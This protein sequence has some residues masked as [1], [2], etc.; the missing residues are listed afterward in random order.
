VLVAFILVANATCG[1]TT[2]LVPPTA[3][4][5]WHPAQLSRFIIGPSP[6][7]T[8]STSLKSSLPALNITSSGAVNPVRA[9]PA[10]AAPPRPPGSLAAEGPGGMS[11]SVGIKEHP[12]S[13]SVRDSGS[14]N[15]FMATPRASHVQGVWVC[16]TFW[17]AEDTAY[18]ARGK[19]SAS[20]TSK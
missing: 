12:T 16:L 14:T 19:P 7:A 18:Y 8:F 11:G 6:S 17:C 3:G 20:Q 13:A 4:C 9:L 5:A 15:F 10:P 2:G 1:F